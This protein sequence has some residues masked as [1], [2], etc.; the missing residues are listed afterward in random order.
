MDAIVVAFAVGLTFVCAFFAEIMS[1]LSVKGNQIV[2]SLRE[3]SRSHS[4]GHSQGKIRK[5]LLAMEVGLTAVLLIGAGLMLKSYERLRTAD[6][7][8]ITKNVLTMHLYL[9]DA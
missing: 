9:P 6:L 3:S 7:G 1:S 4:P 5:W 8:S 2:S